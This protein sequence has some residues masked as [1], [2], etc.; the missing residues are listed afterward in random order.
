ME[1]H[2]STLP[3]IK[4]GMLQA[5][6]HAII[7]DKIAII[8]DNLDSGQKDK[9]IGAPINKPLPT[10]ILVGICLMCIEGSIDLK[11]NQTEYHMEKNDC[12]LGMP[13]FIAEHISMSGECK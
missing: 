9:R 12:L 5:S 3:Q 8:D 4:L 10:K 2:N 6:D 11:L 13:G 1:I 7:F